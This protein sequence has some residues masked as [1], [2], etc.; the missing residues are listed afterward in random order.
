MDS[1]TVQRLISEAFKQ[2]PTSGNGFGF[3]FAILVC[4]S[5]FCLGCAVF[6]DR[7]ATKYRDK[8]DAIREQQWKDEN[9]ARVAARDKL[10]NDIAAKF[11]K[12][13]SHTQK[14]FDGFASESKEDRERSHELD[15]R[16]SGLE[17]EIKALKK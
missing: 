10:Q 2:S 11:D 13:E 5:A 14:A 7:R 4:V 1:I 16:I 3:G 15:K 12:L 8:Q 9:A 6:F 17:H